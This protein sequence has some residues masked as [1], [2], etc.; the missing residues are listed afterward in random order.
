MSDGCH[1]FCYTPLRNFASDNTIVGLKVKVMAGLFLLFVM[2]MAVGGML[3]GFHHKN[4]IKYG[5]R[6]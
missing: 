4:D 1:A 2:L 3:D 6:H 5:E